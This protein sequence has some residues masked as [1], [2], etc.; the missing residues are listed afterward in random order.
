MNPSSSPVSIKKTEVQGCYEITT[1]RH[2][3]LRGTFEEVFN[4]RDFLGLGLEFAYLQD[5]C[6]VSKQNVLRGLHLQTKNP[7]GKLVRCLYGALFDVCVDLRWESPTFL[8][9]HAVILSDTESKALWCPPG[10]AH[11]FLALTHEAMLYYKC[12]TIYDPAS[13]TGVLWCDEDLG[14]K[15]PT[16]SPILSVKDANLPRVRD[17]MDLSAYNRIDHGDNI[18]QIR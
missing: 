14:I 12:S 6:S 5:N 11:G 4:Y 16:E 1:R 8:K 10:T 13:D 7:Q 9:H 17:I 15:W 18:R 3:D 2:T